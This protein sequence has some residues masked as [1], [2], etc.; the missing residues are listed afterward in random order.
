MTNKQYVDAV[1]AAT[2]Q[3]AVQRDVAVKE[4]GDQKDTMLNAAVRTYTGQK[5]ATTRQYAD[6]KVA[7][8]R[9]Y[10]DEKHV[11]VE[12]GLLLKTGDT[13]T[14]DLTMDGKRVIGFPTGA[15]T[16]ESDAASVAQVLKVITD[17]MAKNNRVPRNRCI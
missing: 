8:V 14:G 1:D 11:I 6:E 15:S 2:R 3:Y 12:S 9:S 10:V 4:Y 17:N 16:S 5:T 13:M 7:A